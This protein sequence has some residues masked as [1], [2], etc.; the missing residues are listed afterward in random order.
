MSPCRTH[1]SRRFWTAATLG[2]PIL[3]LPLFCSFLL[4]LCQREVVAAPSVDQY[5]RQASQLM[6]NFEW[7]Q[8]VALLETGL[9]RY[10][11][12]PALLLGLGSVLTRL[13][14]AAQ[15]EAL[16]Q[17]ALILQPENPEVLRNAAQAQL[18]QGK[19]A[20]AITL[21]R[22]S[23]RHRFNDE[24]SH[25]RLAFSLLLQGEER[26][27]LEHARM[28]VRANPLD[29]SHRLLYALLLDIRQQ[30]A[31]SYRQLKVARRLAPRDASLLFQLSQNRKSRGQLGQAL[32]YLQQAVDLDPENPLYHTEI[33]RLYE[34]IG[35]Q[36]TAAREAE[37]ASSLHSAF[38]AYLKA[39]NLSMKQGQ[40]EA[41]LYLA[42][43]IRKHPE[44]ITGAMLLADLYRK[45]GRKKDALRLY[46]SVLERDPYQI[47]AR[48]QSA[49][50]QVQQGSLDSALGLLRGSQQESPN[51]ALIE[52]YREL[53][54]E[55]WTGALQ[56]F[57]RV[58]W[59]HP[60]DPRLLQLISFC[61]NSQGEREEALRYLEKAARLEPGNSDI[62]RQAREIRLERANEL[63]AEEK[64]GAALKAFTELIE[65]EDPRAEYLLNTGY[66]RQQLGDL[67]PAIDA[68]RSGLQL[69][70]RATW[71]RINLAS[72]L[73]QVSAYPEAAAEWEKLLDMD[74]TPEA[75]FPLGLC[76][77]RLNRIQEAEQVFQKALNLGQETP[78]LLYN[79]GIVR[80][81][82]KK[83]DAAWYLIHRAAKAGYGPARRLLRQAER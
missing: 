27:A 10:P 40:E 5:T 37:V 26:Q 75:Y 20:A 22:E 33:S 14:L 51:Q 80:L 68:Y 66:C 18:R 79:L 2:F 74:E 65:K 36:E 11:N 23:L 43:V 64:W 32:E 50:I 54:R 31:E 9:Q 60:L 69:A 3:I 21:F 63:V 57:Q 77:S 72:S 28:A 62:R 16:L 45:L 46:L 76:Y 48:E 42:P 6:S 39:L 7:K 1:A 44:F 13:G 78:V 19:V 24:T 17:K 73:Y 53:I 67:S 35:A 71:A 34:R 59:L 58:E 15:G 12:E 81:R 49:W 25:H 61:F 29:A 47:Q 55:N 8:A 30:G 82:L 70:P 56:R 38:Q 41:A 52:G 83:L 4:L